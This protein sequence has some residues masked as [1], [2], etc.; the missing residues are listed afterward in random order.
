MEGK[1]ELTKPLKNNPFLEETSAL[2]SLTRQGLAFYV[3]TG[4]IKSARSAEG[5]IQL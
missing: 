2:R 1:Y 3:A 4:T 5:E